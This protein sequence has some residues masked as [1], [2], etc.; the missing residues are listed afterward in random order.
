MFNERK[1]RGLD[2]ESVVKEV[3]TQGVHMLLKRAMLWYGMLW[4]FYGMLCYAM[5]WYIL[6]KIRIAQLIIV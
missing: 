5:L 3:R 2:L 1:W 4:G 6:S